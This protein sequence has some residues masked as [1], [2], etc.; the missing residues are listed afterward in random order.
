LNGNIY[1]NFHTSANTGGEIRGQLRLNLGISFTAKLTGLQEAPTAV[2]SRASGTAACVLAD[3]GNELTYQVTYANLGSAFRVAH[4]HN[5]PA[6]TGGG[7]VR[8]ISFTGNTAAGSWKSSDATQP[9]TPP[10][11][12]SCSAAGFMSMFTRITSP[13][14][15]FAAR[16]SLT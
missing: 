15:K 1:A 7:V 9:L 3:G 11:S 12:L 4:F 2:L 16:L 13:A 8:D 6:G 14:V 10:C 5:A